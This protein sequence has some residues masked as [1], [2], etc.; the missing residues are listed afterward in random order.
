MR[1][2]NRCFASAERARGGPQQRHAPEPRSDEGPRQALPDADAE[3][4]WSAWKPAS[5]VLLDAGPRQRHFRRASTAAVAIV[6]R[7]VA[8]GTSSRPMVPPGAPIAV[9]EDVWVDGPA[10]DCSALSRA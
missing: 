2:G 10:R 9:R 5:A 6:E 7:R 8:R 1:V 3:G 4:V